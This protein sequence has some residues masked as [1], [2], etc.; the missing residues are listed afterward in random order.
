MAKGE[1][2][3]VLAGVLIL[4]VV[5]VFGFVLKG[6][7]L[8]VLKGLIF[9]ILIIGV[10][11]FSKKWAAGLLDCG[12]EHRIWGFYRYGFKAHHHFKK[13]IPAGIIVPLFMLFFSVVFLWPAGILIKFMGILTYEARV[14]KR[15]AAHRFGPYSYSELTEWHNGLI[16]VAGIVGLMFLAVIAYF[17]GYGDLS[18]LTAYYMFCNMLPISNLD[19]TQIFFGNRIVWVVLE[20][21]TLLFVAYALVIPV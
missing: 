9:A 4:F 6:D 12:V 20:V 2:S 11:I 7:W 8:G 16:G 10:H 5:I 19:G 18:V 17:V 1:L 13:E 15:R 21:I 14:L 3:Q